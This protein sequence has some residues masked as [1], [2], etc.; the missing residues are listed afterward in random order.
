[1]F[2]FNIVGEELLW[3]GYVQARLTHKQAWILCSLFWFFF[4]LPFGFDLLVMLLPVI[5]VIPYVFAVS[6][7]IAQV[8]ELCGALDSANTAEKRDAII[9]KQSGRDYGGREQ[10]MERTFE[11]YSFTIVKCVRI[12]Q[13]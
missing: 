6:D 13:P 3:R 10:N 4:H 5:I 9:P 12:R 11:L 8:T 2:F 7:S 1:M